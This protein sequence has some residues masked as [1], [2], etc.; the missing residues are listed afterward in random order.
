MEKSKRTFRGSYPAYALTYFFF[1]WSL[2]VFTSV[3]SM[4]LTGIGKSKAE[5]SFIMSAS[6]LFG[7]V[8]IPI[9]GYI[10]D[11]LRKPRLICTVMMA[12]VAVFGILFALVRET[13]LLFLLNGCIMGFIS[14]LS[15]V[16]ERMATSTKY[17]YGT[18]RIWG[19]F[20]YAAAVQVACAMMEFTSPQLI[21]VSVSVSAVAGHCGFPRHGRH[22][23][24]GYGSGKGCGGQA[25][26][27]SL[28]A[29][30]HFVR[31]HRVCFFGLLKSQHDIQPHFIAGARH[32]DGCSGHSAVFQYDC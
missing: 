16:S 4:Y 7:V 29:D 17:R 14:S 26:F 25:V 2:G 20:G 19:T 31:H 5:M 1:Y 28:Y 8:L 32:A 24:Y 18:I 12:C 11:K 15:P 21:F 22:F 13:M 6:S 23:V 9:V 30:V 10:N 27:I 3:L